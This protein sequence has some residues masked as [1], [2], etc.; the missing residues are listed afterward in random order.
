MISL[1]NIVTHEYFGVDYEMIWEIV[2]NDLP[3]NHL[4]LKHLIEKERENRQY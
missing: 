3:K 2:R 1:R 4:D